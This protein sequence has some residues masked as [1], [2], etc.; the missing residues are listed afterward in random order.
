MPLVCEIVFDSLFSD[1]KYT[2]A[3]NKVNIFH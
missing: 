2:S 3:G 1:K